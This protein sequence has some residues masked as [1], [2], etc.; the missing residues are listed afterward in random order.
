MTDTLWPDR[1]RRA[2]R[3]AVAALLAVLLSAFASPVVQ[4]GVD[5]DGDG[6]DDVDDNCLLLANPDQ[7]DSDND[8]YGNA[9]DADLDNNLVV[10]FGDLAVFPVED[11]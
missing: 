8:D 2:H 10:S 11:R 3:N 6:T 4:A 1:Q 9:C 7:R 5:S